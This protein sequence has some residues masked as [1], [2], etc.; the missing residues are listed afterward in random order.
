M[1]QN[2]DISETVLS[3]CNY[4]ASNS[5]IA[6][7][8]QENFQKGVKVIAGEVTRNKIPKKGDAPYI[9]LYDFKKK[10]GNNIEWAGY[11]CVI[12]I[13]ISAQ[14]DEEYIGINNNVY[15]LDAYDVLSKF[16]NLIEE[17]L[18][19]REGDPIATCNSMGPYPESPDG[20]HWVGFL[21]A[22]WRIYQAMGGNLYRERI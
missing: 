7:F 15:I 21:E 13:G 17:V 2:L 22:G 18:I 4:L 6:S 3:I 16:M 12:S 19:K 14:K 8:C 1:I 9:V 5:E 11:T 20:T 10:E